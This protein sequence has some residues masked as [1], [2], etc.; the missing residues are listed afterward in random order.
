MADEIVNL[1]KLQGGELVLNLATGTGLIARSA[2]ESGASV[3]GM[4]ISPG[5]L[6]IARHLS[7][8]KIPLTVG[9]AHR[10]PFESHYFDLI[11]CGFSLSHFSDYV[12]A[13]VE[14]KR[15]LRTGGRFL[16]SA[17][18]TKGK[19]P[20][21]EAAVD[22][23]RKFLEAIETTFADTFDEELWTDPV[24]GKEELE[25][26]GYVDVIVTTLIYSGQYKDVSVA[27]DAAFAWPITRYRIA[28]LSAQDQH[29]LRED[30]IV[31]IN[32]VDDLRWQFEV[33]YYQALCPGA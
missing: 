16:T 1:G 29:R 27:V 13:L 7:E 23:R 20:S 8:G 25:R 24:C 26:T 28:G 17:W 10:L 21:K 12:A 33:D 11:T 5:V 2:L 6:T 9:D 3:I 14:M 30:T 19:N 22:V 18:G 15:V 4:D 32:E 31:A